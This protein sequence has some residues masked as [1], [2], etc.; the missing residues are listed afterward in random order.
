[1]VKFLNSPEQPKKMGRWKEG[2]E[3]GRGKEGDEWRWRK[4]RE[5]SRAVFSD[6]DL[7]IP[8]PDPAV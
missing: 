2:W 1:V 5:G 7:M 8:D 3:R 6:P 4:G